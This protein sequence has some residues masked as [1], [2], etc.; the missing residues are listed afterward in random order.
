[1]IDVSHVTRTFGRVVA[2]DDVSLHVER[3]RLVGLLG[4]NGAGKSTLARLICGLLEPDA[5]EVKIDGRPV[6]AA[7][8][9]ARRRIGLVTDSPALYGQM[10]A[11]EYLAFF[12]QLNGVPSPDAARRAATWIER[13]ELAP[14]AAKPLQ[15]LSRGNRQRVALA[16]ALIHEPD[17]LLLDEP[18]NG[19]DPESA[20]QVDGIIA[21]LRGEGRAILFCSHAL[22]EV[23][24][25]VD[26]A[27]VIRQGKVLLDKALDQAP[28]LQMTV[29]NGPALDLQALPWAA[30]GIEA[31]ALRVEDAGARS[32]I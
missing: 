22:A 18:T 28:R 29:G 12:A 17:V 5:G 30:L 24:R 2:L 11:G 23:E 1:M 31:A 7:P 9:A 13:L 3:G 25:L 32:R 19:L 20:R 21:G 27:L 10:R 16:R 6:G 14:H 8:E 26:R 15:A 4:P